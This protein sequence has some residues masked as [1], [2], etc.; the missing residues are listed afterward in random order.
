MWYQ[1]SKDRAYNLHIT[2]SHFIALSVI[3]NVI[4]LNMGCIVSHLVHNYF[5]LYNINY[6][7]YFS[8]LFVKFKLALLKSSSISH[9][10]SHK[11]LPSFSLYFTVTYYTEV[12]CRLF[13]GK[14]EKQE[15]HGNSIR[16]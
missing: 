11:F 3:D 15:Y 16:L 4:S 1:Q 13:C 14:R 10:G 5:M 12:S 8:F 9:L 2:V 6:Y 7:M